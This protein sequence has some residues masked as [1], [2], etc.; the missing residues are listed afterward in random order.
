MK[1]DVEIEKSDDVE[2][3]KKTTSSNRRKYDDVESDGKV[4]AT[5][6]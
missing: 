6:K 5:K 2:I 4:K 3:D 1:N